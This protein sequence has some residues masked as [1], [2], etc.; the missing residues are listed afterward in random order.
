MKK[1]ILVSIISLL[2]ISGR[3]QMVFG[4][5]G[6]EALVEDAVKDGFLLVGTQYQL[7]EKSSGNLY[8]RGKHDYYGESYSLGYMFPLGCVLP[9]E[10]L[11][12]WENDPDFDKYKNSEKYEPVLMDSIFIKKSG[13]K[14]SGKRELV[15]SIFQIPNTGL[16]RIPLG[17]SENTGLPVDYEFG[18]VSGWFVWCMIP[19]GNALGKESS[20]SFTSFYRTI[21]IKDTTSVLVEAPQIGDNLLGGIFVVPKID[22]V[23][24]ITL[25]T[26]GVLQKAENGRWKLRVCN[27][28]WNTVAV[29]EKDETVSPAETNQDEGELNLVAN[30]KKKKKSKT[31]K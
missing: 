8:G 26:K 18:Q 24:K 14:A 2:C 10:S 22:S 4:K 5:L 1:I 25:C 29:P 19:N 20:F 17:A 16:S 12:P 6:T 21:V 30:G 28:D 31:K 9:E 15:R 11:S 27:I 23:G 7:K 13:K 3:S